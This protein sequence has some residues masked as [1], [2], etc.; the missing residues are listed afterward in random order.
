MRNEVTSVFFSTIQIY[1][2][3]R[4][5]QL[6]FLFERFGIVVYVI[7]YMMPSDNAVL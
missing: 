6:F 7:E 2:K 3:V 5:H 1:R 4:P